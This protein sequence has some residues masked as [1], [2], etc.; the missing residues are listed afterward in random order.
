MS[1]VQPIWRHLPNLICVLRLALVPPIV[2]LLLDERF[3]FALLLVLVAGVSDVIDG[4]L[5]RHF[6]WQSR[7]GSLLDPAADK[8]LMVSL[9]ATLTWLSLVPLWLTAVVVLRDLVIT[10]GSLLYSAVVEP[11][12]AEPS[13]IG[14]L[15][16]ALQL[17]FVLLVLAAEALMLRLP[18]T[19]AL[20]GALVFIVAVISGTDYV[21]RWLARSRER[22]PAV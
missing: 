10:G 18:L 16:T 12:T 7:L 3:A 22:R 19:V 2:L 11:L 4:L 5:A 20:A 21:L 14:K 8:I 15:N 6:G 9:F 13:V 17:G 1:A